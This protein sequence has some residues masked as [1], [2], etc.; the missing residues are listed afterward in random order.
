MASMD[1]SAKSRR[2]TF[3]R[4]RGEMKVI[5]TNLSSADISSTAIITCINACARGD[6]INDRIGRECTMKSVQIR[7]YFQA[8]GACPGDIVFWS[9]VYDRQSNGAAPGWTDVYT[10][11]AEQPNLRNLD[12][13]KRFKVLGSGYLVVNAATSLDG[14]QTPIEFYRKLN[15]PIEFNSLN[16]GDVGDI[17]TGGL[18]WMVRAGQAQGAN[19]TG[20]YGSVRVRYTD[21]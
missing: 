4:S 3:A 2:K 5:D 13:R 12:N 7:G 9:V 14:L 15:H 17:S 16:N 8:L 20:F 1:Y 19:D 6:D 10:T 21:T 18:F 11:A